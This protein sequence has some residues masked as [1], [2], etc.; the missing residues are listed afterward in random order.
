MTFAKESDLGIIDRESFE[1]ESWRI[2]LGQSGLDVSDPDRSD[3]W[4]TGKK[5]FLGQC[6]GVAEDGKIYGLAQP[7]LKTSNRSQVRDYFDNGWTISEVV[8]GAILTDEAFYRPPYHHLRHPLIFYYVHPAVFYVNKLKLSGLTDRSINSYFEEGLFDIGVD[9]MSWDDMS[10]NNIKWPS[11][12]ECRNYRASVYELVSNLIETV[13]GLEEGHD[14]IDMDSPLWALFMGFEHERIHIE[15]SSVLMRE[16]PLNLLKRPSYFPS[17]YK[18]GTADSAS[19]SAGQNPSY[20]VNS[21]VEVSPGE[22][23]IGKPREWPSYG[24]D[25]EY[26][27]RQVS[28]DKFWATKNLITNGEFLEFVSDGGYL[29]REF[30]GEVGSSWRS[31]RDSQHPTFWCRNSDGSYKLRT[32]FEVI[33]MPWSWP[34]VVNFHEARAF[35]NWKSKVD[36][37]DI[38]YRLPT[39]AEHMRLRQLVGISKVESA[40]QVIEDSQYNLNLKYGSESEVGFNADKDA[41]FTDVFGNVWQWMEDHFNSLAGFEIHPYYDDFSTPCFDG[42]HQMI[43]G[44]SF[45][46]IG[47]EASPFARF[48]FRPH[49][50]QHAGIRL[51][52]PSGTSDGGVVL[53]D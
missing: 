35:A 33:E 53:L 17:I 20:P 28:V 22:V 9:E 29:Y 2:N 13:D 19:L 47:N 36:N 7:D 25:N 11:L 32:I 31:F 14:P 34:V 8:F 52:K 46:S 23:I 21:F 38:P 1:E 27:E 3:D 5:P 50:F 44:G 37:S 41:P 49:F 24:W 48:H 26:G 15:T 42:E 12:E 18:N 6:P 4:W 16:L 39:E 10:K 40:N 43:L 51:V 30:W 45:I